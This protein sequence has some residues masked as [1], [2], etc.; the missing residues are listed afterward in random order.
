M[1]K[2][3]ALT[4]DET[5]PHP[6]RALMTTPTPAVSGLRTALGIAGVIALMA[7]A[8]IVFF[9]EKLAHVVVAVVGVYALVGGVIY[10]G[11]GVFAAGLD[12]GPR[13]G[14]VVL[15]VLFI[16]A[17]VTAVV[18]VAQ[19]AALLAV[20]MAVVVGVMWIA[21]GIL[22]LGQARDASSRTWTAL[23]AT[24]SIVA[25]VIV[26]SSPLW[27]AQV[28]WWLIGVSLV[29]LGIAQ[30]VRAFSIRAA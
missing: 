5:A 23:F 25:G 15:G 20:L 22:A 3:G 7:G 10:A 27:G 18:N 6:M 30:I 14:T 8:L 24:L 11:I 16:G 21:E 17:G 9:P 26:L 4:C 19:T 1:M 28:I 13:I 12:R 29:V 2:G